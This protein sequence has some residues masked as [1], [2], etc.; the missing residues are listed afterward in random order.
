MF[1]WIV[2]F[3]CS[4]ALTNAQNASNAGSIA[5][6]KYD[7]NNHSNKL[8]NTNSAHISHS[9]LQI[10][11]VVGSKNNMTHSIVNNNVWGQQ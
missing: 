4:L 9:H 10:S 3:V 5:V 8:G 2:F 6:A 7:G 11:H 1:F